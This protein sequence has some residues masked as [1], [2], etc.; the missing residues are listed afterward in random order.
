MKDSEAIKEAPAVWGETLAEARAVP[1]LL[2]A[3]GADGEAW[4]KPG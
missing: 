4:F 2:I 1:A 3:P